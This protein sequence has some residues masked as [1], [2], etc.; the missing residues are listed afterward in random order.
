MSELSAQWNKIWIAS[1]RDTRNPQDP[2]GQ[3][4]KLLVDPEGRPKDFVELIFDQ[5][6][7]LHLLMLQSIL[8]AVRGVPFKRVELRI[9]VL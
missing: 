6:G 4:S 5:S 8:M 9:M 7:L 1:N 3:P 2:S